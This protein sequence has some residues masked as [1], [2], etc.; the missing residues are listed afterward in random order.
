MG[1]TVL[2]AGSANVQDDERVWYSTDDGDGWDESD[3]APSG[4]AGP[5]Y[6]WLDDDFDDGD[7][8][9]WAVTSGNEGAVSMTADGGEIFNQV[10]LI[11]MNKNWVTDIALGSDSWMV[12]YNSDDAQFK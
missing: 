3:K 9:A 2:I 4:A 11:G 8:H 7:G 5:T 1:S 6:V 10:S 12:T